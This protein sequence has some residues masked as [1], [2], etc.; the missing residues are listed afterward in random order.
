MSLQKHGDQRMVDVKPELLKEWHPSRNMDFK[1]NEVSVNPREGMWWI[2]EQGHEWQATI[3]ARLRG[4]SCPFCGNMGPRARSIGKQ[5]MSA[6]PQKS[7]DQQPFSTTTVF[8]ALNDG[9]SSSHAGAELRKSIRYA[10]SETVMVEKSRSDILGYAQLKNFSA[11][12]L[13]LFSDVAMR[14]GEVIKVR[15]D[16]PLLTSIPKTVT[17]MVVWCRD[18]ENQEEAISRFGIGLRLMGDR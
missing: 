9:H 12:G 8:A 18:L 5:P 1:A 17:S 16:K 13:M 4:K 7:S 6:T 10:R 14:P 11:E 3:R 2:C 15:F